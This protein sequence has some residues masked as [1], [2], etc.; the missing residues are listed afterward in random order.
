MINKS[1]EEL[2][3]AHAPE[4]ATIIREARDDAMHRLQI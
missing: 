1:Q 2:T 3:V 4:A